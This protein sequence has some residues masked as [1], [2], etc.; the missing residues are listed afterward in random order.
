MLSPKNMLSSGELRERRLRRL[1]GEVSVSHSHQVERYGSEDRVEV[2]F[3]PP[4]CN[5]FRA[6]Q[7]MQVY[8]EGWTPRSRR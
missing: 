2:C 7:H 4:R 6:L 5:P 1:A 8:A 3:S